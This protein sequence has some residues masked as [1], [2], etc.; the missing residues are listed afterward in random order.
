MRKLN[1]FFALFFSYNMLTFSFAITPDHLSDKCSLKRLISNSGVQKR[2]EMIIRLPMSPRAIG[3]NLTH[4][5][6]NNPIHVENNKRPSIFRERTSE[7]KLSTS[8]IYGA[9]NGHVAISVVCR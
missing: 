7:T 1:K 8:V 9:K 3:K 2:V 5:R 6:E 4:E